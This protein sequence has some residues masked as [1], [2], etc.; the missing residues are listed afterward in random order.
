MINLGMKPCNYGLKVRGAW[1]QPN[2]KI[3]LLNI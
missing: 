2:T 1:T 3:E